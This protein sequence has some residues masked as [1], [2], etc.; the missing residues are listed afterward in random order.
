MIKVYY[1]EEQVVDQGKQSFGFIKSPSGLKPKQ[2][3]DKLSKLPGIQFIKPQ[4]VN[5]ADFK[6]CHDSKYVDGIFDLKIEN[7]FGNK[8]QSVNDSL[9]YTNGAML[10]AAEAARS[11][12]PT[13]ALVSGF[14]HAGYRHW[15]GL[16]YFCTFNGLMLTAFKFTSAHKKVAIIDC[17]MHWGNGTDDILDEFG[18][19]SNILHISFGRLYTNPSYSKSYLSDLSMGGIVYSMLS[20][21]KPN[22]ILYQAGADVH[23]DDPYG[24][25][26]TTEQIYERDYKMFTIA[27]KLRI[28][29]AW[30]LA[31]GYQIAKDGS[32]DKVLEIHLNTFKACEEVYK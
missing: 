20:A 18:K 19:P 26:L 27:Q 4:P 28:P 8:S 17:D 13:C 12:N 10:D 15:I 23:I 21:F 2:L 29:I 11:D 9:L 32:I 22:I 3:A 25:V 6:I 31:G 14:H 1:C 30:N 5:K 7:G 16:G 24:G